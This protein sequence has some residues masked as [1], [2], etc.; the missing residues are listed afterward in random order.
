MSASDSSACSKASWD[1]E[2]LRG[3][4]FFLCQ[5]GAVISIVPN[6]DDDF[7]KEERTFEEPDAT[8][9]RRT[10]SW[11]C[12]GARRGSQPVLVRSSSAR[13]LALLAE[14][15]VVVGVVSRGR[16]IMSFRPAEWSAGARRAMNWRKVRSGW[17]RGHLQDR[18]RCPPGGF[19]S[20]LDDIADQ[21]L[22]RTLRSTTSAP[23]P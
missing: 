11:A 7:L 18:R 9:F 14:E 21:I 5:Q 22:P 2:L 12:D 16:A 4:V 17:R 13:W 15:L 23:F 19:G 20:V 3:H 6:S 8:D 1:A 10:K